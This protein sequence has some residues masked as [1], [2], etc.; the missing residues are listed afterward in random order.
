MSRTFIVLD[1]SYLL[2]FYGVDGFTDLEHRTAIKQRVGEAAQAGHTFVVPQGVVYELGNHIADVR[3]FE[4][5]IALAARF[6]E[7]VRLAL[8]QDPE[9]PFDV[10]PGIAHEDLVA[11]ITG[12]LSE[13]S[14]GSA[15]RKPKGDIGLTDWSTV[16]IAWQ[17]KRN[18]PAARVEIWAKDRALRRRSPDQ[19]P[20]PVPE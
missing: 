1:T 18:N 4:R 10:R 12:W 5:R 20:R 8:E 15:E 14:K 13:L 7:E 16:A 6:A 9:R 19:D 17:I 3:H 2:E 11:F